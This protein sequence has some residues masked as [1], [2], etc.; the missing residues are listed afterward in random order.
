MFGQNN[1]N[2]NQDHRD[3]FS[4]IQRNV[5]NKV[6][7]IG[8]VGK[9]SDD[10]KK[11]AYDQFHEHDFAKLAKTQDSFVTEDPTA[12]TRG[13]EKHRNMNRMEYDIPGQPNRHTEDMEKLDKHALNIKDVLKGFDTQGYTVNAVA[14][15]FGT[16]PV[17][18]KDYEDQ[19][20]IGE[21]VVKNVMKKK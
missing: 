8:D 1:F 12:G 16:D 17:T 11:R 5:S 21:D 20:N 9:E 10:F 14:H 3:F 4:D 2:I 15:A 13:R 7:R 6:T 19:I 18:A